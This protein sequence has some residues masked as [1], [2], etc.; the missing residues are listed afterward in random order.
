MALCESMLHYNSDAANDEDSDDGKKRS[1]VEALL[2]RHV[3]R[4]N[5]NEPRSFS[6]CSADLAL[7]LPE[8]TA[9]ICRPTA[10][11]GLPLF[12]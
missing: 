12:G 4:G 3:R 7:G 8:V 9:G 11:K 10:G 2:R 5:S 1:I 6:Q